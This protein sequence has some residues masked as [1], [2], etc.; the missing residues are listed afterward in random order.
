MKDQ[1]HLLK[2]IDRLAEENENL[3]TIEAGHKA[4]NG[5]LRKELTEVENE[6]ALLKGI[7]NNSPEM[8]A[9][10]KRIKELEEDNKKLSFQITDLTETRRYHEKI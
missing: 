10:Q 3:R 7:G 6:L 8:R 9:L 5:K 4:L 1:D 2:E